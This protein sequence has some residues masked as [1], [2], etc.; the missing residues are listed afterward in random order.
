MSEMNV[1]SK[2]FVNTDDKKE[3][4][5]ETAA[6]IAQEPKLFVPAESQSAETAAVI[7]SNT[8]S[9]SASASSSAGSSA[10]A[11]SSGGGYIA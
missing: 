10:S 1:N 2:L 6:V 5:A 3:K 7:A 8:P 11:G 4:K 9:A